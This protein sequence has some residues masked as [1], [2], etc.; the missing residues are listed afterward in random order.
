MK[1]IAYIINKLNNKIKSVFSNFNGIYLYGSYANNTQ[2][3]TSDIDIVAIF[4]NTLNHNDRLQLWTIIGELELE[5]DISLDLHPMSKKDLM[6]NEI[7]HNQVVNKG[8]FYG[9]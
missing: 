3:E 1:D 9:V 8:V 6:Q 4:E 2:T 7:Y 5:L